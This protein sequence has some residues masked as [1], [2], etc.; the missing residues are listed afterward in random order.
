[1]HLELCQDILAGPRDASASWAKGTQSPSRD[2]SRF[3]PSSAWRE[4]QPARLGPRH[5]EMPM[6][7]EGP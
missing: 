4:L 7:T 1:M 2:L 6:G 5:P 3:A